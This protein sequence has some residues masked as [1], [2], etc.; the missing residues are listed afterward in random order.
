[1]DAKYITTA[2]GEPILSWVTMNTTRLPFMKLIMQSMQTSGYNFSYEKKKKCLRG[3]LRRQ[4]VLEN[5]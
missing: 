4:N 5:L 3:D 1:M 2:S